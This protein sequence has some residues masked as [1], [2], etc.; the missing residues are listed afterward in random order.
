MKMHALLITSGLLFAITGPAWADDHLFQAG[1]GEGAVQT[2][3]APHPTGLFRDTTGRAQAIAHGDLA[4][5]QGSPFTGEH[6]GTP[7]TDND[8]AKDHAHAGPSG[9][10]TSAGGHAK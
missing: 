3:S 5:G 9:N 8:T 7:S 6:L 4:P 1:F 2:N 10:A